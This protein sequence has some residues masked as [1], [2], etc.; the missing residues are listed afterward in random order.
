LKYG[1]AKVNGG[2]LTNA[3]NLPGFGLAVTVLKFDGLESIVGEFC[4]K[5]LTM[6]TLSWRG[7][8]SSVVSA[9]SPST[10]QSNLQNKR[11]CMMTV[12]TGEQENEFLNRAFTPLRETPWQ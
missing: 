8:R 5:V 3:Q 12:L 2:R 6:T 4:D 1:L 9:C 11:G 7:F 10:P